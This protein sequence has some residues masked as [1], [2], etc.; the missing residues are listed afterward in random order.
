MSSTDRQNRL[1]VSEDWKRV[2]QSFKNADFQSYDF[3]NLRRTMIGYLRTNYPEDFNDYIESSEYLALIDLI[4]FLGQNISYRIDL[5]ARENFL[6]LAERRESVLRL[7]RLLS[8]N[9]KRNKAA[10]GLL[11]FESISTTEEVIDSNNFN[12]SGQS[13]VWNDPSN[14]DWYE[15]FVKILNAALPVNG[16]VGRPLKKETVGGIPHEQYRFNAIN[17]D[18]PKYSF[19]KSVSGQSLPFEVISTDVNDGAIEEELPIVANSF[20][21]VFKDDNQG[22]ASSNTGFF[23]TFKQGSLQDG[24]FSVVNPTSN[25]S[26]DIDATNI[27]NDDV[28]LYK[29][30]SQGRESEYWTKV[31]AVEGNNVIYNSLSKKIRNIY[32]VVTRVSDR[33]SLIFS[34]G[35]FGE[36]PKGRFK[37]YYRTSANQQY[38]IKPNEMTGI[39][40][41]IPYLSK[42]NTTETLSIT[43]ELKYTVSNS[44]TSETN[45]SIKQNAPATYYTQNRMITGED[46]NVAPLAVSQEIIKVKS[47]NRIA[48]GISRYYDILDAT[49]KYSSTN[50]FAT[51]GIIYKETLSLKD[52]FS[53][54]TQTDIESAINNKIEPILGDTRLLNF[55]LTNFTKVLVSDLFAEWTNV[56]SDTNRSTGYFVDKDTR[57]TYSVGSYTANNL[58]LIESGT[59]MKFIAPAGRY[60]NTTGNLSYGVPSIV[61]DSTYKWVKVISVNGNGTQTTSAGLGPIIIND[62]IPSEAVLTEIVPKFA[63]S[64]TDS[65][66][67]Q[68]IDQAF[69]NN[70]FG[71]RYDVKARQWRVIT[72]TNLNT[73]DKF[74]TGKT[75]DTSNNNLDASWI[76]R[77]STTGNS[78]NISYRALRYVF[79]SDSEIKFYYDSSDKIYDNKTGKVI[80][81][82]I[83]VLNINTVPDGITPFTEN[84]NWEIIKEYRD[85]DGYVDSKKIE[86]SFFDADDDGVIDNPESF[87]QIVNELV[88]PVSK[89]VLLKKYIT[90]DG[91]EDYAYISAANENITV[92]S[93]EYFPSGY[94]SYAAGDIFYFIDTG[95]FKQ[96]SSDKKAL[97]QVSDYKAFIGRDNLKFRYLHSADSNKRIDPSSTNIIDC[98]LL[99]RGYDSLYRQWINGSIS[100]KPLP[101]SSDN[102]YVSYG[103][104]LD[105]IKSISDEII[106]H[107]VKY[108]VLFGDKAETSLQ[109]TFKIVKNPETVTNDNEI[110]SR[111]IEAINQYF[112]LENWEFGE[113][114]YF[115]ELS[116]YIMNYLTPDLVSIIIV[117]NLDTSV[118]G[119]LYEIKSEADEILISG[120]TVSNIE[121]IDAVTATKLKASGNVI[122]A[123]TEISNTGIQSSTLSSTSSNIGGYGY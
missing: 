75:G 28:W 119:S 103:S 19:T 64:L 41:R 29:L 9:P 101:P 96:L 5:N 73:V 14:P 106:Y 95:L 43:L 40:I 116:T 1:L 88:N 4:A 71:L 8:Y 83:E 51:D 110:K 68:I 72:E 74:S 105:K 23:A 76:L 80:K 69:S 31:D 113:T 38:T 37:I 79:E 59:L 50:M 21:F 123:S 77:F 63:T 65:V 54:S 6:E 36:L 102:L 33:I 93:A 15:Q 118:F 27:N 120:A 70:A 46:Y 53:F 16:T 114:F 86:V 22:P 92:M 13:I 94:S 25:Q 48:S 108:K 85:A 62:I 98:Y 17:T 107:P 24:Q 32:S 10:T 117:P 26:I 2:Y 45:E 97:I 91:V 56:T 52:S 60:F 81:D 57:T 109:A 84:F 112:S 18:I 20:A 35:T 100:A 58:R 30:D 78:Y 115:S 99:T 66:K 3:D 87:N 49:G 104:D 67:T 44:S 121:I 34:D 42:S 90:S 55:Y 12:L 82:K 11:K 122:T 47:V 111:V 61:G 89:Y 7:A 39:Q